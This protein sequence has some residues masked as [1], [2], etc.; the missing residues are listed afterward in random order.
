MKT[1]ATL[2]LFAIPFF[3]FSQIDVS[4]TI[5]DKA[6]EKLGDAIDQVWSA[7]GKLK[8]RKKDGAKSDSTTTT[9]TTTT[10][11]ATTTAPPAATTATPSSTTGTTAANEPLTIK[12]YQNYDFVPGSD[13]IFEDHFISDDDGEFP[14]H[15]KLEA[16]QGVVN[17][18]QTTPCFFLT[19]GN[20]VVVDPRITTANYLSN[21]LSVETD[22]YS[23]PG[24][25]GLNI[26]FY[27]GTDRQMIVSVNQHEA[28]C[29]FPGSSLG[30]AYP[31]AMEGEN[32]INKWHHVAIAYKDNQLKV[33]VDQNRVLVVPDCNCQP[34]AVAF[35]GIGSLDNPIKMT[36][37]RIANGAKMNML[38]KLNT[39]GKI[40]T[41]GITFDV[42]KSTLRPESMGTI[43]QIYKLMADNPTL[44]LEVDG[45]TDS[46]GDDASN[47]KL[48]Q[49]RADAVRTQLISMGIDGARLTSK[50]YGETKPIADNSTLEGKA[51]NRRVEFVKK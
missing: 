40:I 22:V 24:D 10:T 11:P 36:G 9:A 45:H 48:S 32:Y 42:N 14:A 43:N 31:A 27:V 29:S 19:E 30:A 8:D 23:A 12:S 1:T 17:K 6:N 35:G 13:L 20:Y 39:D 7:P 26:F 50:G 38:D 25:Y 34:N 41:Y 15:W 33:Y 46:D 49:D 37:V 44:N 5:N 4:G 3:G 2:L 28:D 16:G 47:M 51:K 18:I 21:A